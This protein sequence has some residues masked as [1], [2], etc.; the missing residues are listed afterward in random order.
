MVAQNQTTLNPDKAYNILLTTTRKNI[1]KRY[2]HGGVIALAGLMIILIAAFQDSNKALYMSFGSVFVAIAI[3]YSIYNLVSYVKA[4]KNVLVTNK[5]ICENGIT[6]NYK[7]KEQSIQILCFEG[8]KRAKLD[9][10]YDSLKK[11]YEYND[12]YELKFKGYEVLY[13]FKSGF[14]NPKDEEFFRINLSKNKKKIISKIKA[15]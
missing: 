9:Y 1:N 14:N 5:N 6:Y 11:A 15:A 2:I 13:V 3:I 8:T 12:Y 7:F 10:K 4:K